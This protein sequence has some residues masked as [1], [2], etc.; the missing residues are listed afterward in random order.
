MNKTIF[1]PARA[2]PVVR[3]AD[4]CV[5]GGSCT[6]VFAAVRA[7]R[8]GMRVV[9][10]ERENMLGGA[11]VTGL[12]NIWHTLKDMDDNEQIIAGLTEEVIGRLH[13]RGAVTMTES[14]SSSYNFNPM[15]LTILLDELTAEHKID[16]M[17]HTSYCALTA[18]DGRVEAVFIENK[19]G[20]GAVKAKFF[21]D[22]TGDGRA[23]RDLGMPEFVHDYIQPPTAVFHLQGN[24]RGVDLG[25]LV[26]EHGAE[27]G[28]PDDWG[29]STHVSGVEGITMRADQHI[30]GV[31]CDR[32]DDLTRAE[33]EGRRLA[34]SFVSM[35]K[36][37]GHADTNYA[38]TN[39]C[40]SLGL[41]ETVHFATR[42]RA[43]EMP[44]LTGMRY[45][46]P[47]LNGTYP[48]DVHHHE[49]G[50]ISFKHLD[51]RRH[52]TWGKGTRT[53]NGNWREEA[54]LTGDP[55]KYYQIPFDILVGEQYEN[56]IAAGRMVNADAGA[57]GALRV[58]VN[59]NQLGE[60]AGVAAALCL[61]KGETLQALDGRCVSE[62]LRKGGS[63]V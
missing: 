59:L 39:L 27:F 2:I 50:G 18:A 13:A 45:D 21:I 48:V 14:R 10:I 22:A 60:A 52:T 61:E 29:W 7:A 42:F 44:L 35:L 38:L 16:V 47:I 36:K 8:L 3:E 55:A 41:R 49:D 24:M 62:T 20:R 9:L 57:F 56:F 15:E 23:A 43:E 4:V 63:A 6:G 1:E 53:E 31:R 33:I 40:A 34:H 17:F 12:V 32:A 37:Y 30:F 25:M 19:D 54:G 51:G 58:M 46:A 26:R 5:L 28:L 11:A